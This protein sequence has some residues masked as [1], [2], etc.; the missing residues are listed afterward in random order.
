MES[1]LNSLQEQLNFAKWKNKKDINE[2]EVLRIEH[3]KQESLKIVSLIN[4]L[5]ANHYIKS[6]SKYLYIQS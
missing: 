3:L 1:F 2:T 6:A 5:N 4:H